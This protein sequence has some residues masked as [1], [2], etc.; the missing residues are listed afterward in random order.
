MGGEKKGE[1]I[2]GFR[3]TSETSSVCLPSVFQT[4]L[5][6]NNTLHRYNKRHIKTNTLVLANVKFMVPANTFV[7]DQESSIAI[8]IPIPIPFTSKSPAM[9]NLKVSTVLLR[10]FSLNVP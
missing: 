4:S 6:I 5:L 3:I 9:D 7:I 1:G 10:I 2:Q 8:P